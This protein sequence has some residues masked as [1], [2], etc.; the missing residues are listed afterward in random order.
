MK[1]TE[2][3]VAGSYRL[4]PEPA[5]DERGFF[6]RTFCQAEFATRGLNPALVQCSV[7]FNRR[8]GTLRGMHYQKAPDEEAKLVRCTAGAIYDVVLDLRPGSASYL[9]WEGVELS[10][11][12]HHALYVPEGCAHGFL[13]LVDDSEVFYQMSKDYRPEAAA[14]V[15]WDD[16]VFGIEWPSSDVIMSE[17][18]RNYAFWDNMT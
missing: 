11:Y 1:F 5:I 9:R 10:A 14:G 4:E 2:L 18:D 6:A 3:S 13:T 12:N 17:R 16:P 8:A 15:R 7:S